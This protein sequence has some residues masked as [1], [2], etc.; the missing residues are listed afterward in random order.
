MDSLCLAR[1]NGTVFFHL[2]IFPSS[3]LIMENVSL[4]AR[5]VTVDCLCFRLCR[6]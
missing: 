1:E 2:R 3:G 4:T 6:Y 5:D